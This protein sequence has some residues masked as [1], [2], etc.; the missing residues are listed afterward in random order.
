MLEPPNISVVACGEMVALYVTSFT[1]VHSRVDVTVL[2]PKN[3]EILA[4]TFDGAA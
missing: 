2:I 1:G 3:S 4:T